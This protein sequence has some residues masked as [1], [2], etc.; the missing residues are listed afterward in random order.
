MRISTYT[1]YSLR[2]LMHAAARSPDLI[3]IQDVARGFGISRNHLMKVTHDLALRGYIRTQRGRTG[4]FRL[5]R[6]PAEIS[7]GE[8]VRFNESTV[9]LV[10]CFD[11]A[12]NTCV[13]APG[14]KLKFVLK[15]AE[16]AFYA[17]LDGVTLKDLMMRPS[18]FFRL[19][20]GR[21]PN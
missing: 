6:P 19:L 16:D 9:P 21:T 8:V 1:D 20:K 5:A 17:V 3:T 14:C 15:D 12:N 18:E 4:G 2:L 10:E 7:I 11:R 13:I